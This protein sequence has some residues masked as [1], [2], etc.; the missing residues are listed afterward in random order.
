[1][2][3]YYPKIKGVI[4]IINFGPYDIL[5]HELDNKLILQVTSSK[6]KVKV[7]EDDK[8]YPYDF[9]NGLHFKIVKPKKKPKARD[10]KKFRFGEYSF[11]LG[12]NNAGLLALFY[13]KKLKVKRKL[14]NDID[15]F[16]FAF[17]S[18]PKRLV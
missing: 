8:V 13:N 2:L 6:G 16:T 4:M 17:L 12:I 7:S 18:E 15:T 11:I 5:T 1:V 10:L 9:P 3:D 14:I